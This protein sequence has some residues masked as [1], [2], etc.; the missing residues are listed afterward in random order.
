MA[1]QDKFLLVQEAVGGIRGLWGLP[2]GGVISSYAEHRG[3]AHNQIFNFIKEK[4]IPI[5]KEV[6]EKSIKEKTNPRVV[7]MDI[8]SKRLSAIRS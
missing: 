8:A 1:R 4:I 5:T 6:M 3:M 7:A 2:G